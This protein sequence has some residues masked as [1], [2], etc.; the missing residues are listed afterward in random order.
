MGPLRKPL[1]VKYFVGMLSSRKD[2][3]SAC[4]ELLTAQHGPI[5]LHSEIAPWDHSDYYQE[6]MGPGLFR[7]FVCWE[8]LREPDLL[9][10]IKHETIRMEKLWSRRCNARECREINIDPGYLT[11]AKVV[12]ATTKDYAHRLFI[13]GNVYAEVELNY[14]KEMAGF[15]PLEHTYPDFRS[16]RTI[17]WFNK[18]RETLRAGLLSKGELKKDR[19]LTL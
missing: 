10:A 3:F 11:E 6:E 15:V 18:A 7:K 19:A 14:R 1:P 2:L 4:E 13:G 9:S 16:A 5:D 8:R 17:E 12:L